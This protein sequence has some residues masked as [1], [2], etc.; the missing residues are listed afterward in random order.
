[1]RSHGDFLLDTAYIKSCLMQLF[2]TRAYDV[3]ISNLLPILVSHDQHH[4]TPYFL[5]IISFFETAAV[6]KRL[7][8]ANCKLF[9][10]SDV[11]QAKS[12]HFPETNILKGE[13]VNS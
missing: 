1:M 3:P 9:S 12:F 8:E 10:L 2:N 4:S 13:S 11:N 7:R 5:S 6:L